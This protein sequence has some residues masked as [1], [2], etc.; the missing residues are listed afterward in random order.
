MKSLDQSRVF[1]RPFLTFKPIGFLKSLK[2]ATHTCGPNKG[3]PVKFE[4]INQEAA[5]AACGKP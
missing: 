5:P 1:N 4:H 3:K 2:S